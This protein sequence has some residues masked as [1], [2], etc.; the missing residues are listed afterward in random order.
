MILDTCFKIGSHITFLLEYNKFD[1]ASIF[2]KLPVFNL[3]L[4]ILPISFPHN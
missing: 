3:N 2:S 4:I 1:S